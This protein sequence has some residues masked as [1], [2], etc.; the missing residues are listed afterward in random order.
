MS[1]RRRASQH[2]RWAAL[3]EGGPSPPPLPVGGTGPRRPAQHPALDPAAEHGQQ[4]GQQ[5]ERGEHRHEHGERDRERNSLQRGCIA[6][7]LNLK[8]EDIGLILWTR[9]VQP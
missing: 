8:I 6:S 4:R 7:Q 2:R 9:T 1:S 3:H 5:G